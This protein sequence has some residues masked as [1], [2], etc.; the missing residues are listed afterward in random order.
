[1]PN[2]CTGRKL[3]RLHHFKFNHAYSPGHRDDDAGRS[4]KQSVVVGADKVNPI[5]IIDC[6]ARSRVDPVRQ[7]DAVR[8]LFTRD[9]FTGPGHMG[10]HHC[11]R[12]CISQRRRRRRRRSPRSV[13]E[14][15]PNPIRSDRHIAF[16]VLAQWMGDFVARWWP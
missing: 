13:D 7:L 15:Q 14:Q 9:V 2:P 5:S 8:G 10:F 3:I 12:F 4:E 11:D 1:M 16:H 6:L